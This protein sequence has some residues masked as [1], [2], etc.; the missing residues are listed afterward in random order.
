MY[1]VMFV[2]ELALTALAVP[3]RH[4]LGFVAVVFAFAVLPLAVEKYLPRSSSYVNL[5]LKGKVVDMLGCAGIVA[6]LIAV[7]H[8]QLI[9]AALAIVPVIIMFVL[10]RKRKW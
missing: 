8:M 3:A 9:L 6:T 10:Y 4:M 5:P 2:Y 1:M 7:L